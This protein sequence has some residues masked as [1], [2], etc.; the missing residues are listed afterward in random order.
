[1]PRGGA[2]HGGP[3]S[4][5]ARWA[6][7]VGWHLYVQRAGNCPSCNAKRANLTRFHG[8]FALAGC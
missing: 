4:P 2:P 5:G 6:T 3:V 1:M 7:L 8:V